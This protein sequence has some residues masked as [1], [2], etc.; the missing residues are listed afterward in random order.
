MVLFDIYAIIAIG[1]TISF[2]GKPSINARSITPSSPI[3]LANGSRK[4]LEILRSV[5]PFTDIFA[6]SQIISPAGAAT[7]TALDKTKIVLSKTE[8]ISSCVI[9]GLR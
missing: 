7:A 4:P 8:R 1:M 9:C 3:S 6:K 5:A 2:A